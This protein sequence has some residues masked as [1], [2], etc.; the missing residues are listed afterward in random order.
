MVVQNSVFLKNNNKQ[1]KIAIFILKCIFKNSTIKNNIVI[2]TK[3]P[4][5]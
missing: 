5:V 1:A 4:N 2:K 3:L